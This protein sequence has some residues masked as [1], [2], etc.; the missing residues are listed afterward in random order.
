MSLNDEIYLVLVGTGTGMPLPHR[1]SPCI[2]IRFQGH[3]FIFDIGPGS[4]R[5]LA[6]LGVN[7]HL[8]E[9]IWITHF[10]PDH[11]A[12]LV[13]FIFAT[14]YPKILNRRKPFLLAGPPGLENF[15]NKV[16]EAYAPYLDLPANLYHIKELDP[17]EQNIFTWRNLQFKVCSTAHTQESIAIK[18]ETTG[19]KSIVYSSDTDLCEDLI[20]L[21]KGSDVLILEASFPEGQK[22]QGHLTPSE[23][24]I[25]AKEAGVKNLVLT[26]FY[27]ECLATDIGKACRQNFDGQ[28]IIASDHL[29][30]RI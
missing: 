30:L 18:M 13:H 15:I 3:S 12:D 2:A 10:H 9:A 17:G 23:A 6:Q 19:G 25:I 28:I 8:L 29:A 22:V 20:E 1:G 14:K 24:G 7:F 16:Q 4:L 27:P 26:H 11:T 21:S 5:A